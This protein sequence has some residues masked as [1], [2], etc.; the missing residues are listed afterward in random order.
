MPARGCFNGNVNASRFDLVRSLMSSRRQV[1]PRHLV[2]P[3]PSEAQL[4]EI[5]QTAAMAPDHRCLTPWRFVIIGPAKRPLLAEAFAQALI[6]RDSGAT[7]AQLDIARE[8]A[9][10]G[11]V[12]LAGVVRSRGGDDRVPPAERFVSFGAALQ[13]MLLSAQSLG[14]DSGLV[15]G[16]STDSAP[17]RALFGVDNEEELVCFVAFGRGA[18]AKVKV[19]R[20]RPAVSKYSKFL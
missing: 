14:F 5:L 12:L 15:S 2:D 1:A 17:V 20:I 9:Y 4:F 18:L 19:E 10:R 3:G 11:P 6:E 8:K 7:A 13:N 16:Q